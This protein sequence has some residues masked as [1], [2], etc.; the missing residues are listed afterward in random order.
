[1]EYKKTSKIDIAVLLFRDKFIPSKGPLYTR[2]DRDAHGVSAC[3][4][5]WSVA[6]RK[7]E[8]DSSLWLQCALSFNNRFSVK[9]TVCAPTGFIIRTQFTLLKIKLDCKLNY[10]QS[11]P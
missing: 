9:L 6:C 2:Q 10:I 11:L 7:M 3:P 5:A 4:E 1:M 8:F